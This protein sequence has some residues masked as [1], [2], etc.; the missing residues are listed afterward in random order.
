MVGGL[1][2]AAGRYVDALACLAGRRCQLCDAVLADSRHFPLCP[3]CAGRL[4]PR[5]GGYCPE[6]GICYADPA[7]PV[8]P[9]LA[10]RTSPPLW[11]ALAFHGP[12]DGALKELVHRHKFGHEHGLGRLLA[13]LAGQA[14]TLR[15]LPRPD[16]IVPVPMLP[17][18]VLRRGF[19]QS[20]EL[21]RMLGSFM[22]RS[23]LLDGLRKVRDTRTQSS[24]GRSARRTNVSG[25]FAASSRVRGL[26]IL[27]VDDVMTTGATLAECTRACLAAGASRVDVFALA[28]AL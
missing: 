20:V 2:V 16:R 28:R 15:G 5:R 6:C 25:A 19:N 18:L 13:F 1:R 9:C 21:A 12:Y 14:W 7:A 23:P 26:H 27:I 17:S 10:C 24:L 4:A 11:S 22:S 3:D 8:Y